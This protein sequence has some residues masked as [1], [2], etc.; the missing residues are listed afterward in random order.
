ME[1]PSAAAAH[2]VATE[3]VVLPV[4]PFCAMIETTLVV[5]DAARGAA[6]AAQLAPRSGRCEKRG[7]DHGHW[8]RTG[9]SI[10][11]EFGQRDRERNW[12]SQT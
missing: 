8:R 7:M 10:M 2:A 6:R 11:I 5:V 1:R 9:R 3:S 4:P 12:T